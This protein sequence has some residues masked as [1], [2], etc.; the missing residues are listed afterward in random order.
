MGDGVER[1]VELWPAIAFQTA[2]HIARQAFGVKPDDRRA[3]AALFTDD[4]RNMLPRIV[5]TA[6]G[7][8]FGLITGID[9]QMRPAGDSQM[10][11][12][13]QGRQVAGCKWL[14]F[15]GILRIDHESR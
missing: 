8:Y 5:D 3:I 12:I 14:R 7:D 13:G 1:G 15:A 9:R 4:Q 11:R 2:K 6:E 10:D